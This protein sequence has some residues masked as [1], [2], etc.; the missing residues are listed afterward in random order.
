MTNGKSE[1]KDKKVYIYTDSREA[2]IYTLYAN[3]ISP[4]DFNATRHGKENSYGRFEV[5]DT[6][7]RYIDEEGVYIVRVDTDFVYELAKYHGFNYEQVDTYMIMFK[8]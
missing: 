5:L 1:Y 8:P 7:N 3:P 2:Y 6:Q 4:Y